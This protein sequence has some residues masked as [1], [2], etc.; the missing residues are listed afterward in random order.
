M[1]HTGCL[2]TCPY[3]DTELRRLHG[4]AGGCNPLA[5]R[6][7]W[8]PGTV[9]GWLVRAGVKRRNR[10]GNNNPKGLGGWNRRKD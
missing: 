5:R 2:S 9:H 10:G 7:G 1:I 3:S 8:S 4:E 6:L